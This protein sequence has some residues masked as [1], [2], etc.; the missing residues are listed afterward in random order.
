MPI[1]IDTCLFALE[2]ARKMAEEWRASQEEV[3]AAAAGGF[4]LQAISEID[5]LNVAMSLNDTDMVKWLTNVVVQ[6]DKVIDSLTM[7]KQQCANENLRLRALCG[8]H[9]LAE[10]PELES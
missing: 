5:R 8:I 4:L 9:P 1:K 10:V 3:S 2:S 6:K 7:Q